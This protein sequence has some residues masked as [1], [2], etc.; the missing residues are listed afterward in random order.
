M[1]LTIRKKI[2]GGFF[3]VIFLVALMSI[4]TYFKIGQLTTSLQETS[5]QNIYK[6]E[7]VQGT[8][9]DIANEAVA[10]RR[11]NY[12]GDTNDIKIFQDYQKEANEKIEKLEEALRTETGRQLIK[13]IHEEKNRYEAIAEKS[14]EAKRMNNIEQVG[15][16]MQ[17]AG[18]PYKN[19][20]G[21]AKQLVDAES[22][23]AKAEE[24]QSHDQ[25]VQVQMMLLIVNILVGI[26]SI[27][28][29]LY[30]SQSIAKPVSH[31]AEI[32]TQIANGSLHMKDVE[33]KTSDEIG[34]LGESFNRMKKNLR[35]IIFKV[36]N[37]S[38]QLAASSEE[39]TA[40]A[41]QSAEVSNQV[42][43]SITEI[44]Y[45][46]ERQANS[47]DR[48]TNVAKTMSDKVQQN[49][50]TVQDVS[51][52]AFSTSQAAEQG[53]QAVAQTVKQMDEIGK[54]A[55]TTQATIEELSKSSQEIGEI[56]SLISSIAGQTNLLALNAAI[57]AA[58]AG[59][60]GRGF[61]VVA[62][63]VR[64]LAEESNQA[65]HKIGTL[66]E[67]NKINLDQVV[68]VTQDSATGIQTGISLVDNTGATFKRIVDAIVNLSDQIK[69]ISKSIQEISIGNQELV[70]S[71]QEID[72]AS[73]KAA[74]ESQTVS[75]A[76]EEQSASMQEIASSSQSLAMLATELQTAIAKFQL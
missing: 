23:F 19:A 11:F 25:A 2:M 31:I 70:D 61:A 21:A 10:M 52:I 33:I 28:I 32:A 22:K 54:S 56:V 75:A 46:A 30:I 60:Q 17:Q 63:E 18:E 38:E 3:T 62:E 48:I 57:E 71:I 65:A 26:V 15:L 74:A 5:H 44:A 7:L 72:T 69:D 24:I 53:N 16:Y 29:S 13:K 49:S 59:E 43:G 42:A 39:L 73:K 64:K 6:T 12:T 45:G 41:H 66:V 9:I 36:A 20:M 76:T 27:V 50:Q 34:E 47:A 40:S 51:N 1:K 14:F 35:D 55:N 68:T 37:S 67:K 58:R 4:F 8:A